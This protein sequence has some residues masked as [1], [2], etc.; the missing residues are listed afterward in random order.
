MYTVFCRR[1]GT[2]PTNYTR[3][4]AS[5]VGCLERIGRQRARRAMEYAAHGFL[6]TSE[7]LWCNSR[8]VCVS[9]PELMIPSALSSG[10]S[11]GP[12]QYVA[13]AADRNGYQQ[14]EPD[15]NLRP[16]SFAPPRSA[17]GLSCRLFFFWWPIGAIVGGLK[18][19]E[20]HHAFPQTTCP[21]PCRVQLLCGPH[22]LR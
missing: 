21:A 16:R 19:V 11:R 14:S 5:H 7:A 15:A 4:R 10:E 13:Q 12:P 6:L 3:H 22:H 20:V 9:S 1:A 8:S 17:P 18:R 2:V